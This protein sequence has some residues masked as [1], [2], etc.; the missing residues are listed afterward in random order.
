MADLGR[1]VKAA[2][3]HHTGATSVLFCML[4]PCDLI[5]K[6]QREREKGRLTPGYACESVLR[7][8]NFIYL[9]PCIPPY[10]E[11][12]RLTYIFNPCRLF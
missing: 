11:F 4:L 2:K 6:R 1:F 10:L 9:H 5:L 3:C 8:L 12:L 7:R